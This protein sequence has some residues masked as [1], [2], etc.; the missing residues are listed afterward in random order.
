MHC[1][2]CR[3]A[4]TAGRKH[5]SALGYQRFRCRACGRRFKERIGTLGG[6]S[7][8]SCAFPIW[9]SGPDG[10]LGPV[11]HD[12]AIVRSILSGDR[13]PCCECCQV[14]R[15]VRWTI[16]VTLSTGGSAH[17][18]PVSLAAGSAARGNA[19]APGSRCGERRSAAPIG[20]VSPVPPPAPAHRSRSS[21]LVHARAVVGGMARCRDLRAQ[22]YRSALAPDGLAPTLGAQEPSPR[23][24]ATAVPAQNPI[25]THAAH[26]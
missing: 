26:R 21:T 2:H 10:V 25:R 16:W 20:G 13:S 4:A 11:G 1:P 18:V 5:R 15:L 17:V 14:N 24:G 9:Q 6:T 23:T 22:R 19:L 3:P 12:N 7:I 8:R